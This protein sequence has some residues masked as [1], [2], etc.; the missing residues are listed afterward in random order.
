MLKKGKKNIRCKQYLF[1][2]RLCIDIQPQQINGYRSTWLVDSA[3]Q[4]GG[5]SVPGVPG[6]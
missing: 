6:L 1:T 4:H 3:G 5:F 2:S